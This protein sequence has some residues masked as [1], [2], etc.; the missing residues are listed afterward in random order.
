MSKAGWQAL[1]L[2]GLLL[3]SAAGCVHALNS[4]SSC[5]GI[6]R[7]GDACDTPACQ[8]HIC[9]A[10]HSL[11][12]ALVDAP[13]LPWLNTQGWWD[14]WPTFNASCAISAAVAPSLASSSSPPPYCSGWAGLTCCAAAPGKESDDASAALDPRHVWPACPVVGA[15]HAIELPANHISGTVSDARFMRGLAALH[16]CG[17]RGLDFQANSLQGS[18]APEWGAL[19]ELVDVNVSRAAAS[20]CDDGACVRVRVVAILQERN[21]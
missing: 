5:P 16:A 14:P 10:L 7:P 11:A 12:E 20:A 18:L 21:F 17:L 8:R 13:D 9:D 2:A 4:A 3:A 19:A 1:L 15:P 6:A